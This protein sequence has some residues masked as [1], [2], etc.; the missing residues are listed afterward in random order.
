MILK[1][2]AE[3]KHLGKF[4]LCC[5]RAGIKEAGFICAEDISIKNKSSIETLEK[6]CL[7]QVLKKWIL[8]E[9]LAKNNV[10]SLKQKPLTK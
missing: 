10:I 7:G 9:A 3:T 5:K 8:L 1:E 2:C 6:N 4:I